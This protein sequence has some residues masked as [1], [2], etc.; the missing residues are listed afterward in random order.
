MAADWLSP[1]TNI[2]KF[3]IYF[4]RIRRSSD[5]IQQSF[6]PHSISVDSLLIYPIQRSRSLQSSRNNI[7]GNALKD[8][9]AIM[10]VGGNCSTAALLSFKKYCTMCYLIWICLVRISVASSLAMLI[11]TRYSTLTSNLCT[12]GYPF[13]IADILPSPAHTTA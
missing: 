10:S 4:I 8:I 13:A 7:M 3:K 12:P 1:K 9:S 5:M 11:D 6:P 2:W